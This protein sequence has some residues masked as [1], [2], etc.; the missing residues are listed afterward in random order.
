MSERPDTPEGWSVRQRLP[1]LVALGTVATLVLLL[2]A[3]GI[4]YDRALR[5]E[6]SGPYATLPSPAL[7][8]SIH[9]GENDPYRAP[10]R[11]DRDPRIEAA[12]RA[13]VADGLPG[14]EAGM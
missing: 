3:A 4:V 1:V 14:W 13:V 5:P 12:K 8:T 11:P 10:D 7:D 6:A 2:V 9:D